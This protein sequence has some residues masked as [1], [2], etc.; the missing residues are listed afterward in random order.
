MSLLRHDCC[1]GKGRLGAAG[2]AESY[3]KDPVRPHNRLHEAALGVGELSRCFGFAKE[4]AHC[5]L[6]AERLTEECI[7]SVEQIEK[8]D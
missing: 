1:S 2:H 5:K 4:D 6:P 3:V 8:N 7:V